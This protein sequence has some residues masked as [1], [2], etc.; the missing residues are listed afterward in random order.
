ML[1]AGFVILSFVCDLI[2]HKKPS[3]GPDPELVDFILFGCF[4]VFLLT[5][6]FKGYFYESSAGFFCPKSS[7]FHL[8]S[9]PGSDAFS[10]T[11]VSAGLCSSGTGSPWTFRFLLI[12]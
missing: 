8:A 9:A 2:G 4:S 7:D 11:A 12:L 10:F 6:L 5:F 3:A 1:E